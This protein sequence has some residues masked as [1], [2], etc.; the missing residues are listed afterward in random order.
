MSDETAAEQAALRVTGTENCGLAKVKEIHNL[1]QTFVYLC[2]TQ[3]C[4]DA[5]IINH[6]I[7]SCMQA[8]SL[9]L[10]VR[11]LLRH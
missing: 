5:E 9:T 6:A 8:H 2:L 10:T 1:F 3:R 4:N 7:F 11:I